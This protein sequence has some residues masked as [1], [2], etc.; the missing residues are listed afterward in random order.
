MNWTEILLNNGF[1]FTLLIIVL[2]FF[3]ALFI[4]FRWWQYHL[5]KMRELEI[6]KLDKQIE[7]E[8]LKQQP[9]QARYDNYVYEDGYQAQEMQ[10]EQ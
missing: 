8:K 3:I 1:Q 10:R 2:S 9:K 5:E 6:E 7:L 4:Y